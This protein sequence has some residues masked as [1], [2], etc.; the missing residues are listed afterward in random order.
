M[1][2]CSIGEDGFAADLADII[3]VKVELRVCCSGIESGRRL[4]G[5]INRSS[6]GGEST[7]VSNR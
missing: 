7:R 6:E 2:R 3:D 1:S 5:V 4:E